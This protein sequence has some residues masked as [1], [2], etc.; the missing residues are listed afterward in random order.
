MDPPAQRPLVCMAGRQYYVLTLHKET[1]L[2]QQAEP[3][4]DPTPAAVIPQT[5]GFDDGFAGFTLKGMQPPI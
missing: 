3:K 4:A 5:S 1:P 2:D